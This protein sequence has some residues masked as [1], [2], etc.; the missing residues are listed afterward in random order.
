MHLKKNFNIYFRNGGGSLTSNFT[1]KAEFQI[2]HLINIKSQYL[3]MYDL[4]LH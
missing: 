1:D 2:K 4:H 3:L